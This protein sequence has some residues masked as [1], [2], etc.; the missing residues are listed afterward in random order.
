M[1]TPRAR[2]RTQGG[3][4]D[5][6][7]LPVSRSSTRRPRRPLA[8]HRPQPSGRR[9]R[10]LR[11][12]HDELKATLHGVR[13]LGSHDECPRARVAVMDSA[14]HRIPDRPVD[15]ALRDSLVIEMGDLLAE[16]EVL[17]ER[18]S[19]LPSLQAVLVI[20]NRDIWFV[21]RTV[22]RGSAVARSSWACFGLPERRR[23]ALSAVRFRGGL[24]W[25]VRLPC[26]G[27]SQAFA[28]FL[29]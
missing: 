24:W 25:H 3:A 2:A 27:P 28:A 26:S 18:G 12:R 6:N 17:Q 22:S 21:V 16:V 29:A 20:T 15:D 4:V 5:C 9:C 13:R 23:V 8:R 14:G 19:P 10:K 7:A 11:G 1:T